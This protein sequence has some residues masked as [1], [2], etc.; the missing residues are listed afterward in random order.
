MNN[1][2]TQHTTAH[3]AIVLDYIGYWAQK[4]SGLTFLCF[5]ARVRAVAMSR[6]QYNIELFIPSEL[7]LNALCCQLVHVR[8]DFLK[9]S[10]TLIEYSSYVMAAD[11]VSRFLQP[12]LLRCPLALV[13]GCFRCRNTFMNWSLARRR[14]CG[15][16]RQL[17]HRRL[18]VRMFFRNV[19][20]RYRTSRPLSLNLQLRYDRVHMQPT[21]YMCLHQPVCC[22]GLNRERAFSVKYCLPFSLVVVKR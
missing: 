18:A 11:G 19:H 16:L 10:V 15:L 14:T 13:S 17:E 21:A 5:S 20:A 22:S 1:S 9:Y 2:N 3:Q 6:Q 7:P 12:Q 8:K 4:Y